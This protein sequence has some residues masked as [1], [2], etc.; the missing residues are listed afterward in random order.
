MV[1]DMGWE[2]KEIEQ[3]IGW[4]EHPTGVA[5]HA[6]PSD[7]ANPKSQWSGVGVPNAKTCQY[8]QSAPVIIGCGQ[9]LW[10]VAVVSG[11]DQWP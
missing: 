9:W 11:C 8:R 5:N 10:S 3:G 2:A 1:E 7:D 6:S 4:D